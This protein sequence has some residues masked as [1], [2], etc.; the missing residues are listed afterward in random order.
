M[1][2]SAKDHRR[3][4]PIMIPCGS[5]HVGTFP[6]DDPLWIETCKK[7]LRLWSPCGSKHVG[8]FPADDPLWIETCDKILRL[9]SLVDRNM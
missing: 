2:R 8:M 3:E 9:W 5:K 6:A 4:T 1:F 7:I